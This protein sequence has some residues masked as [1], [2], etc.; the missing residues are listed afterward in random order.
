MALWSIQRW[1]AVVVT[2]V[3]DEKEDTGIVT[4]LEKDNLKEERVRRLEKEQKQLNLDGGE[5]L[6]GVGLS[7]DASL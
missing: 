6:G 3:M 4:G 2:A 5:S 7:G 1:N